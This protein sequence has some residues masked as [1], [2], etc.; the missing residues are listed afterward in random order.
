[1]TTP[2]G[3]T[4]L[5]AVVVA[6]EVGL[7]GVCALTQWPQTPGAAALAAE[8]A[9]LFAVPDPSLVTK[10]RPTVHEFVM[11]ALDRTRTYGACLTTQRVRLGAAAKS[12]SSSTTATTTTALLVLSRTADLDALRLLVYELYL[13]ALRGGGHMERMALRIVHE[14]LLPP[15]AELWRAT[16]RL[17]A[18]GRAVRLTSAAATTTHAA[19]REDLLP[20][21]STSVAVLFRY[22]SPSSVVRV[23]FPLPVKT[24]TLTYARAHALP[25]RDPSCTLPSTLTRTRWCVALATCAGAVGAAY[26]RLG[27]VCERDVP[28]LGRGQ[29]G[30]PGLARAVRLRRTIRAAASQQAGTCPRPLTRPHTHTHAHQHANAH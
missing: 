20:P 25:P 12:A 26:G 28:A 22:L 11:T 8:A 24:H 23:R 19:C 13:Q 27:R 7:D 10:R 3:P 17:P 18:L 6:T 1:M 21:T 16:V 9:G 14:V 29:R 15:P 30:V 2:A 5:V 4:P